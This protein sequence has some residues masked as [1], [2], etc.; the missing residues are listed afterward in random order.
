MNLPSLK[1][2]KLACANELRSSNVSSS[3]FMDDYY[4]LYI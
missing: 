4:K 3:L 2:P 1:V